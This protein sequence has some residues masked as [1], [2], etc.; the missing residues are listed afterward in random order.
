M[1]SPEPASLT[2]R[3][4]SYDPDRR[5]IPELSCKECRRRKSKVR[6]ITLISHIMTYT[7]SHSIKCDR[8]TPKC[9]LCMRKNRTCEYGAKSRP[10]TRRY[11]TELENA[12]LNLQQHLPVPG[13]SNIYLDLSLSESCEE[14][15]QRSRSIDMSHSPLHAR[16][17]TNQPRHLHSPQIA[18]PVSMT[19][20][21]LESE[22]REG[23]IKRSIGQS[24]VPLESS[25]L[26]GNW[27]WDERAGR[28]NS[29]RFVDGMASLTSDPNGSGYLGTKIPLWLLDFLLIDD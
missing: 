29:N 21:P 3:T 28:A 27:E 9:T 16:T 14:S 13:D 26:S 22:V 24:N 11:V 7:D 6:C 12:L 4:G 1:S 2:R 15:R 23:A 19:R 18:G 8:E 5:A 17:A 20:A 25:P 10:L